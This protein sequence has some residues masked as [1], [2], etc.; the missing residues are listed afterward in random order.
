[1]ETRK[2]SS[3]GVRARLSDRSHLD[4]VG[5]PID[6]V[7]AP[8]L[9]RGQSSKRE[10]GKEEGRMVWLVCARHPS[11]NP[12]KGFPPV[13]A[14]VIAEFPDLGQDGRFLTTK[15]GILPDRKAGRLNV[16]VLAGRV[17]E[18]LTIG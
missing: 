4:V 1:M 18:I 8:L 9:H 3:L 2:P 11:G 14:V 10:T 17:V 5:L 13:T 6:K 16:S 15:D 7:R 12:F